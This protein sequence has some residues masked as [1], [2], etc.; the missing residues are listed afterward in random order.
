[1][2]RLLLLLCFA[3]A[4]ASGASFDCQ[5][6]STAVEQLIC[7]DSE[8]SELDDTL[9]ESFTQEVDSAQSPNTLRAEQKAWLQKRNSCAD[10]RCIQ[11]QYEARIAALSCSPKSVMAG[12]ARGANQCAYFSLR[13][14][15][16]ELDA[17]EERYQRKI[18]QASD[19]PDY[20]VNTFKEERRLWRQYRPAQC[21][22]H[23]ALEGGSDG[24]KNAFA[25]MCEVDETQKRIAYLKGEMT[26][27]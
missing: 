2:Y 1:M 23:G 24:W 7:R 26:Q 9:A 18:G 27:K 12:S 11:H 6:A 4:F 10:A 3:P 14:L 17:L 25:G 5:R 19:N 22:L 15:D 16:R 21:A 8:L 20:T 13:G